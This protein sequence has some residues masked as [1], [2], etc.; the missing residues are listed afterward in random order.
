M[1]TINPMIPMIPL[2]RYSM[3]TEK[4]DHS[5]GNKVCVY[6]R[7][8]PE[9]KYY[10]IIYTIFHKLENDYIK[11]SPYVDYFYISFEKKIYDLLLLR[12][13]RVIYDGKEITLGDVE[14]DMYGRIIKIYKQNTNPY[15]QDEKEVEINIENIDAILIWRLE[16]SINKLFIDML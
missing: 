8:N 2:N 9:V 11:N 7:K 6:R 16:F 10:G 4:H 5:I 13:W 15:T 14:R 1:N 3:L 12:G